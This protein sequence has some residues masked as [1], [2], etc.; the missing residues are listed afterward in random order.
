MAYQ[1]SEIPITITT[2]GAVS[3]SKIGITIADIVTRYRF[4]LAAYQHNNSLVPTEVYFSEFI[5]APISLPLTYYALTKEINEYTHLRFEFTSPYN[6]TEPLTSDLRIKIEFLAGGAWAPSLGYNANTI[7]K[8]FPCVYSDN[9][10]QTLPPQYNSNVSCDFYTYL[11]G[12]HASLTNTTARGPYIIVSGFTSQI[13]IGSQVR[14]ELGRFLIGA[15]TN[16]AAYIRFSI[17]QETPTMLTK[18]VEL[19]YNE[20]AAFTTSIQIIPTA[21]T[22]ILTDV[23]TN[24]SINAVSIHTIGY[25]APSSFFA[26]IYEFDQ[27]ST[28]SFTNQFVSCTIGTSPAINWCTMLGYPLN[29]IVEYSY[30]GSF[31]TA[32]SSKLNFTNGV[33]AGTFT[34]TARLF[35]AASTTI[36]KQRFNVV[37]TPYTIPAISY[38]F[39][40]DTGTNLYLYKGSETYFY[41]DHTPV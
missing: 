26:V 38:G 10:V 30:L 25:S 39:W 33:Y 14:L 17:I 11:T 37:Y 24:S 19:Y 7:Y 3:T 16:L 40:M 15:S 36:Y 31:G 9:K 20:F 4:E 8:N 2:E 12:P 6:F 1:Y 27:I 41:I 23:I 34:G 13:Y 5:A 32:V 18:Y 29:Y 21:G 35:S 22:G 28:P